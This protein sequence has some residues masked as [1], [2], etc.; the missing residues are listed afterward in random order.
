M[1][2][3]GHEAPLM[4]YHAAP[5]EPDGQL[6][7]DQMKTEGNMGQPAAE[8]IG[9][10]VVYEPSALTLEQSQAVGQANLEEARQE[11]DR[12]DSNYPKISMQIRTDIGSPIETA[13]DSDRRESQ[14]IA[15]TV[16]PA[17]SVHR[18]PPYRARH[19]DTTDYVTRQLKDI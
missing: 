16:K 11:F 1:T 13:D 12:R 5:S 3:P 6:S 7:I 14:A 15:R 18:R 19:K 17:S 9:I 8:R 2:K 4:D 10:P